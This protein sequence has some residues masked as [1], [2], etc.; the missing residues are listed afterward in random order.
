[1]VTSWNDAHRDHIEQ[2]AQVTHKVKKL[3]TFSVKKSDIYKDVF[4]MKV[5]V[6]FLHISE[7]L[8]GQNEGWN[9]GG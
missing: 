8:P 2:P 5:P 9:Q 1:M 4:S 7:Q 6:F 3:V